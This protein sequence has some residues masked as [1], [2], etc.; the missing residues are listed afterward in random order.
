MQVRTDVAATASRSGSRGIR[1]LGLAFVRFW[2]S[3]KLAIVLIGA[4]AAA[5]SLG[6][7]VPQGDPRAIR[8]IE[9]MS[10][11]TK[12]FLLAIQAHNVYYSP[13]FLGLLSLFFLNLAVC[14][15]V[16]V[17][18][19]LAFALGR[20]RELPI[21]ARWRMPEQQ[22]FPGVRADELAGHLRKMGYRTAPMSDGGFAADKNRLFRFAPMV[23]HLGLFLILAGGIVAG[24]FG[25]KHVFPLMAGESKG[26]RDLV[27]E[28]MTRGALTP[29]PSDFRVR[30]DRFWM[31]RHPDG[32]IKQYYSTLSI[33]RGDKVQLRK[34]IH[35]NEPLVFEG[36]YYYQAFWGIA[37]EKLSLDRGIR[38][39]VKLESQDDTAIKLAGFVTTRFALDGQEVFAYT[40]GPEGPWFLLGMPDLALRGELRADRP[41]V[42]GRHHVRLG[43]VNRHAGPLAVEL[44][45]GGTPKVVGVASARN[46]GIPGHVSRP[47]PVG[48]KKAFLFLPGDS[49]VQVVDVESFATLATLTPGSAGL[50]GGVR[51]E[52]GTVRTSPDVGDPAGAEIEI[53]GQV[54]LLR[55]VDLAATG[56]RIEG[57]TSAPTGIG[58]REVLL[59]HKAEPLG[60]PLW[61]VDSR[62]TAAL[63]ILNPGDSIRIGYH[64]VR[65]DGPILFSGLQ[66]KADPGIPVMYL[67]FFVVVAGTVMG[68]WSHKQVWVTPGE[69]G[70]HLAGKAHRGSL[71]FHREISALR[72][73]LVGHAAEPRFPPGAAG[74]PDP[75][76]ARSHAGSV[77]AASAVAPSDPVPAVMPEGTGSP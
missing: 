16:R 62:T 9:G 35:V 33:L 5:S 36:H 21:A 49:V 29:E 14:T 44:K 26:A 34:T 51:V 27:R 60:S 72:E 22:D 53:D 8:S 63:G 28:A 1:S 41:L 73:R 10:E 57:Q 50:V 52:I 12:S 25:Y 20:P 4:I 3:V 59:V 6:T 47:F 19:R 11:G 13:W 24:L 68:L 71:L 31:D 58:G 56:F 69:A 77:A 17:W 43:S 38:I 2:S 74:I 70:C 39:D 30:L 61:I 7:I 18:P 23:V 15:Y 45:V 75:A 67:G 64:R 66:T 54:Q 37:G 65:Y 42:V 32:S 48:S 55:M 46:F 40:P 76:K